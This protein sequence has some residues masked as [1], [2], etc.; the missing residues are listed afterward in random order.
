M[1]VKTEYGTIT[2]KPKKDKIF[3]DHI[4]AHFKKEHPNW[5][6][7]CKICGKT[8]EEIIKNES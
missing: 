6:V 1:K 3:H 2:T 8:Y 5:K 7:V 4:E